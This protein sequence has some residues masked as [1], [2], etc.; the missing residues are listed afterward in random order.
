MIPCDFLS[1]LL[2]REA[3][4]FVQVRLHVTTALDNKHSRK[5]EWGGG[6]IEV[7]L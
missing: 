4:S 6:V 7:P 5:A 3:Q 1:F 2:E